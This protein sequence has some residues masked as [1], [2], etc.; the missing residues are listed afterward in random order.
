MSSGQASRRDLGA[1]ALQKKKNKVERMAQ[2]G[3]GMRGAGGS[4][5]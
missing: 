3:K 5:R 4:S 1:G 2:R